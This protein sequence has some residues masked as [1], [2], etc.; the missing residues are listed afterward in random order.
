MNKLCLVILFLFFSERAMT[1]TNTFLPQ[2]PPVTSGAINI[3]TSS[4]EEADGNT[5]FAEAL[6]N[7]KRGD[8]NDALNLYA[9]AAFEFNTSKL[10]VRYGEA[11]LKL[12]N[13]HLLMNHYTE[14]EQV[15]LNVA[16]KNYSK[17][18]SKVGQME[19]YYQLGR[20]YFAANKL[21]QSLWFYTQQ[22]ILA[23]QLNN[24]SA[25]VES[26]IGI[27]QV[28]IKKKEYNLALRDLNR[29][30]LL[31]KSANNVQLKSRIKE[32]KALIPS[33]LVAKK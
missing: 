3:V 25:Y 26:V 29:A 6:K 14:A 27:A 31:L 18:G 15:I 17:I 7:E 12:G 4:L 8:L 30:E 5:Y 2:E 23:K 21:T 28:K 10:F 13:V 19:S 32:T 11:L 16:L 20:I 33:K 9:K 1:Q 22:G 24:N